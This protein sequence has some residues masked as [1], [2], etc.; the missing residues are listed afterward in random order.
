MLC[1]ASTGDISQIV[2]FISLGASD[3][4]ARI[5]FDLRT[6]ADILSTFGM[7]EGGADRGF[8][9]LTQSRVYADGLVRARGRFAHYRTLYAAFIEGDSLFMI[10]N[11]D[12]ANKSQD[13]PAKLIF[14]DQEPGA[15]LSTN[16]Q[17]VV[18]TERSLLE[19]LTDEQAIQDFFADLLDELSAPDSESGSPQ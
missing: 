1:S 12:D 18:W 15:D 14:A 6:D 10:E 9:T 5:P 2:K 11:L 19:A 3:M 8:D 17:I 4:T 16:P 7:S 13:R